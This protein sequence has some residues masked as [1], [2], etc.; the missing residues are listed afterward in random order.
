MCDSMDERVERFDGQ[1]IFGSDGEKIYE[2]GNY[3]GGGIAGVVYEAER[4]GSNQVRTHTI[5]L[6][7]MKA[8]ENAS[9]NR[10]FAFYNFSGRMRLLSCYLA[11][12]S[13]LSLFCLSVAVFMPQLFCSISP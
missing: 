2:L 6:I 3:L 1:A 4:V 10:H 11:C 7:P 12:I 8:L 9:C 5:I 13:L